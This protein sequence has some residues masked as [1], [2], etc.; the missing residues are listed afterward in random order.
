MK[1]QIYFLCEAKKDNVV[2]Q[3]YF[4]KKYKKTKL[5]SEEAKANKKML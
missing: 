5:L 3:N 4:H 1:K 2:Y